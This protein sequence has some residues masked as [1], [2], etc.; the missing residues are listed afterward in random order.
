[1]RRLATAVI[2]LALAA[3]TSVTRI[4][5]T[6]DELHSLA[7]IAPVERRD[8]PV[9]GEDE[10]FVVTGEDVV[11]IR[12]A[13]AG[14]RVTDEPWGK[15]YTL[16]WGQSVS[17]SPTISP[18]EPDFGP[19]RVP[20][21]DVRGATLEQVKPD[22]K[23]TTALIIGIVVGTLFLTAVTALMISA[24]QTKQTALLAGQ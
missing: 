7:G 18:G 19:V 10:P 24:T 11:H 4:T 3:C 9:D 12:V 2:A 22:G 14:R 13:Q 21:E 23:K 15:L 16:R 5:I 1:M 17:V 8:I 6:P 20:V